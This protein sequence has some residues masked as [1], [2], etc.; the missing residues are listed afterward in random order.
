MKTLLQMVIYYVK[1]Y[2]DLQILKNNPLRNPGSS[3]SKTGCHD[4]A[5][6][7]LKVALKHQKSNEIKKY[8]YVEIIDPFHI[9]II[10]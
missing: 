2:F 4:I 3:N 6:I 5:E 8:F 1:E 9:Q 7:L 10:V